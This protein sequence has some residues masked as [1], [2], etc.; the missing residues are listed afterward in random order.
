MILRPRAIKTILLAFFVASSIFGQ[1]AKEFHSGSGGFAVTVGEV[2]P[3]ARNIPLRVGNLMLFGDSLA[4]DL[5]EVLLEVSALT[6]ATTKSVGDKKVIPT[7]LVRFASEIKKVYSEQK[8]EFA[9]KPYSFGGSSGFEIVTN[10]NKHQI[11]RIFPLKGRIIL[12]TLTGKGE[13][14]L[15]FFRP[16]IDSFRLLD[17]KE[18]TIAVVDEAMPPP[19]DQE[20]PN[21]LPTSDVVELGLLGFVNRTRETVQLT[22]KSERL[23]SRELRF[24]QDGFILRDISFSDGYPSVI[25]SWGWLGGARI[26]MQSPVNYFDEDRPM[27][28]PS[29][30]TSGF[31]PMGSSFGPRF[32]NRFVT[33]YDTNGRMLSRKCY[34]NSEALISVE[35]FRYEGKWRVIKTT[36]SSG[37][38]LSA[39]RERFDSRHN[40]LET[41]TL[42]DSGRVAYS[43]RFE[44]QFDERGNWIVKK[45]Y[46]VQTT[47]SCRLT[48][49]EE[50]YYREI[51]YAEASRFS[52]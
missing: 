35:N 1:V 22:T 20:R 41:Q 46:R 10:G 23:F 6:V 36:D 7:A 25:T 44:Y 2:K 28:R 26:N 49:P 34:T 40:L 21:P 18:R 14:N 47:K 52:D 45:A 32:G 12:I 31:S 8:L 29:G 16:L 24:N 42:L 27:G 5:N 39:I 19:L 3:V 48:K 50:T 37:G 30:M 15:A 51:E 9:E 43:L 17:R 13:T 4:F 38:F 33:T 11:L